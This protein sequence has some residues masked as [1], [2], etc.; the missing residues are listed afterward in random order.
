MSFESFR[1]KLIGKFI[2]DVNSELLCIHPVD[3]YRSRSGNAAEMGN[4]YTMRIVKEDGQDLPVT[5]DFRPTRIN[6]EIELGR[7][8]DV[9]GLF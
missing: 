3:V 4:K 8:V 6:V 2:S 1:E 7:I 9:V 5:K